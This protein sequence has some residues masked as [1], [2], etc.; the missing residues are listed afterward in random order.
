MTV[1]NRLNA[2]ERRLGKIPVDGCTCGGV[3]I[4]VCWDEPETP[5]NTTCPRCGG[6]VRVKVIS[7]DDLEHQP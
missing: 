6:T 2:L 3:E 1:R 4:S 7:L 5:Q